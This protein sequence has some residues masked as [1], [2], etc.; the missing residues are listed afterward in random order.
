MT[1]N[2]IIL[3]KNMHEISDKVCAYFGMSYGG[4]APETKKL[5]RHFGA[6]WPCDKCIKAEHITEEN[7]SEKIIYI[8]LHQL[9]KSQVPLSCKT[10]LRTLAHELAHLRE[11]NHG[12]KFNALEFEILEYIRELGYE[13]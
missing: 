2:S 7:C 12:A 5:A 10:I 3:W 8:R 4:I 13:V 9:N 1:T 11:W 6:C